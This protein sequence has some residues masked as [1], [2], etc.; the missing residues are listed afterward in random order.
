MPLQGEIF[1]IFEL[2]SIRHLQIQIVELQFSGRAVTPT[3]YTNL[4]FTRHMSMCPQS[5]S[6]EATDREQI[7]VAGIVTNVCTAFLTISHRDAGF[8]VWA[9][10]ETSGTITALI[11]DTANARMQTARVL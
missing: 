11:R 2:S 9:N 10:I 4:A 3:D 8:S 7:I 1:E 5:S 6:I